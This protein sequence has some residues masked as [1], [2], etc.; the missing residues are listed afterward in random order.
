[1][2][3]LTGKTGS[4]KSTVIRALS[5]AGF[6]RVVTCTTRP[7]RAGEADGRDY[8]FFDEGTFQK[9]NHPPLKR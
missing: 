9:V 8:H 6:N 5:L 3:I 4:G 2:I 1:M 7:M